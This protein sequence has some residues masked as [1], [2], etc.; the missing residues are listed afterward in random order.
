MD[1]SACD[2]EAR[3]AISEPRPIEHVGDEDG[4]V[5]PDA[6]LVDD[7]GTED[8]RPVESDVLRTVEALARELDRQRATDAIRVEVCKGV[9]AGHVIR[10]RQPR[11][12]SD[13]ELIPCELVFGARRVIVRNIRRPGAGGER[14]QRRVREQG[15][16]DGIHDAVRGD[17]IAGKLDP[18]LR[19]D[20]RRRDARQIAGP[21][22]RRRHRSQRGTTGLLSYSL[23]VAEKEDPVSDDRPARVCRRRY[24]A[25]GYSWPRCSGCSPRNSHRARRRERTRKRSRG[26]HSTLTSAWRSPSRP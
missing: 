14:I 22:L 8:P 2:T 23:K 7:R 18:G 10:V 11:I 5:E 9:S 20:N 16:C 17:L 21:P 13:V 15:L 4:A 3:I 6:S 19:V 12:D 24:S 1:L 25:G 26:D